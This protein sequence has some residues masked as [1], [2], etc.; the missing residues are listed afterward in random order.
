LTRRYRL[1]ETLRVYALERLDECGE[2]G[3]LRDRHAAFVLTLAETAETA[4]R[5]A[6][7]P[8]W[9]RRLVAEHDNIRA[10]LAWCVERGDAAT[11]VRL[12]GSSS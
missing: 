6:H 4:L 2:T 5:T 11:A 9:L 10:A 3:R 1:L 12:A 8:A 7:Q